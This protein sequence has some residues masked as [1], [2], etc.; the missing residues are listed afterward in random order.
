MILKCDCLCFPTSERSFSCLL[1]LFWFL[2]L[3][4]TCFLHPRLKINVIGR[5]VHDISRDLAHKTIH[6]SPDSRAHNG[7]SSV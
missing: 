3:L 7:S 5:P 1:A 2:V 6:N 4:Y